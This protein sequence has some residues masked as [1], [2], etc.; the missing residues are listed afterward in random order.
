MKNRIEP[1]VA[2]FKLR[3]LKPAKYNPRVI[4][5]EALAGL[6][7]SIQKFGCVEVLYFI[8]KEEAI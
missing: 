1:K 6:T 3:D 7:V 8:P 2:R 5:A 4:S